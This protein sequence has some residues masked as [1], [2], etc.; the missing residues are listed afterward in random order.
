[1]ALI[2]SGCGSSASVVRDA[3]LRLGEPIRRGRLLP[4]LDFLL[5][6]YCLF[7]AFLLPSHCLPLP[8]LDLSLPFLD[9]SLPFQRLSLPFQCLPLPFLDLFRRLSLTLRCL[10]NDLSLPFQCL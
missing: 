10:F 1:M 8:F 9:H 7:T 5:P 4:L 3:S 2:T 6:F